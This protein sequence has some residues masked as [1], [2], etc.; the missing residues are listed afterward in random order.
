MMKPLRAL[1]VILLVVTFG[2]APVAAS[3]AAATASDSTDRLVELEKKAALEDRNKALVKRWLEELWNQGD[4]RVAGVLLAEDFERHSTDHPASGP[5]A[6]LAI[7][8]SCH[9]GFPDSNIVQVDELLAEGDR[10]F[11]RWRWTGTHQADF[12]GVPASGKRIDVL[13]EDVIRI[14]DGRITDVWPLFD[15]LRVLL[16]IGAIEQR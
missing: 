9:D 2:S 12:L 10:V 1:W 13:G 8:K 14:Q 7:I 5:D 3:A 15:P 16:Q 6:Y 11:V 4:Y